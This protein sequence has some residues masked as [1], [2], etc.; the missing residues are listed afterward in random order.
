MDAI[1]NDHNENETPKCYWITWSKSQPVV[2][3]VGTHRR[4]TS[5]W[6]GKTEAAAVALADGG[7]PGERPWRE[8][9]GSVVSR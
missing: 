4:S 5:R 7:P 6:I 9:R 8:G 3:L 2:G 1:D